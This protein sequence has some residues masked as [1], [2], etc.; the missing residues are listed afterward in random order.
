VLR[1]ALYNSQR[2]QGE[3]LL[4]FNTINGGLSCPFCKEKI[5]SGVGF[6]YGTI[7]NRQYAV[8]DE[9]DWSGTPCRP[10]KKPTEDLVKTVGYFNCDNVRCSSWQDCYP[11]IQ[12]ALVTIEKN[13]IK[14]L[15]IYTGPELERQYQI[16]EPGS[17][18]EL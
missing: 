2:N 14:S 4:N 11:D 16:I 3:K 18:A 7:D 15:A 10:A 1:P 13:K 17:L 5:V 8:G 9:I 12:T 6:Q